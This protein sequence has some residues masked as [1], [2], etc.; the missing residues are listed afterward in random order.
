MK[1][2]AG[3][4]LILIWLAAAVVLCCTHQGAWDQDREAILAPPSLH[5][6]AGTDDLG[7]DRAARLAMALLIGS[8]GALG[9]AVL[10][11][12]FSVS[13]SLGAVFGPGTLGCALRYGSDVGLALPWLF[14][15]MLVRSLLPLSMSAVT[16]GAVT[17]LL[18]AL[19]S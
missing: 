4:L 7:R 14:L 11:T 15:L 17:L 9:T 3:V 12:I 5:H 13:I 18:L 1:R 8:A 2:I 19:F 6:W 16:C 10:S